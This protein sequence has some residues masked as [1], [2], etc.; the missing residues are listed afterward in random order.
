MWLPVTAS[1]PLPADS[2]VH[3]EW[4]WDAPGGSMEKTCARARAIGLPAIAFTDH[5]DFTAWTSPGGDETPTVRRIGTHATSGH[6]DP[7]GY[8]ASLQRCRAQYPDLHILAGV[9]LGEPHVFASQAGALLKAGTFDRVLGSLHTLPVG[10]ALHYAPALFTTRAAPDVMRAYLRETLRMVETSSVFAILAHID[11]PVRTWPRGQA[12][13]DPADYEEEY[14]AVLK[15]LAGSGRA[16]EVN[17]YGRPRPAPSVVRWWYEEGGPAVSF[18]SDAHEPL[19]VARHFAD[20]SAM[21]ES[22][23]FRPGRDP[24]DLWRR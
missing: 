16:L 5:A 10:G 13:F 19:A 15:A 8:A 17:T 12:P 2:H 14:R 7:Q 1:R 21:V 18:G 6:L 4:S 3:T 9:E 20:A 22:C 24:A 23:G 11:F